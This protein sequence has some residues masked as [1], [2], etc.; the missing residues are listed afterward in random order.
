MC[1]RPRRLFIDMVLKM[2]NETVFDPIQ[3]VATI[4]P[5]VAAR[6]YWDAGAL[7]R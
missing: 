4:V 7:L 2:G 1:F 3:Y 6:G 5:A